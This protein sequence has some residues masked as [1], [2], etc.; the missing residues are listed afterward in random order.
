MIRRNRLA[1]HRDIALTTLIDLLVQIIF[2]FTLILIS[3][4]VMGNESHERG[5]VTPEAWKTLISIFDIDPRSL[6]DPGAQVTE[7]KGKYEKLKDD[8]QACDAKTGACEKQAGRGPGNAPCR[9][10][11]GVEMVVAD[12]TIDQEGRIVVALGRHA[13]ELQSGQPLSAK[14]LGVPL[15]VEQFGSLFRSWREHGLA[16]QPACA[17]K[18]EVSYDARARAGDYE[19]ARRAIANYFTLSAP[20][21]RF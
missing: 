1:R 17:F 15:S 7:I 9:D 13:R 16:R 6:R 20:P 4:D 10:A 12:A 3:A 2:V 5:W 11:A 19:P 14:A 21:K 8:L 18:A